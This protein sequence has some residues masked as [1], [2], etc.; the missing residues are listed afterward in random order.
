MRRRWPPRSAPENQ[1]VRGGAL[2]ATGAVVVLI[3]RLLIDTAA[4]IQG[5]RVAPTVVAFSNATTVHSAPLPPR[6]RYGLRHGVRL[7]PDHRGPQ[8]PAIRLEREGCAPGH[9]EELAS[10]GG[11]CAP[12][13]RPRAAP[14][15]AAPS[16]GSFAVCVVASSL[17]RPTRGVTIAKIQPHCTV[18]AQNPAHFAEHGHH[19]R[20]ILIRGG[21]ESDLAGN[22]VVAQ[23]VVRRRRDD[24]MN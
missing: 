12:Y 15:R 11:H 6:T 18:V 14:K 17:P 4:R 2:V 5:V 24:A 7:R 10:P 23:P 16:A 20:Y 19:L 9:A 13:G 22:L 8:Q 3:P 21:L 1:P